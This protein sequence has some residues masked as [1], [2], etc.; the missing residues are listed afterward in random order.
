MLFE[1]EFLFNL[2]MIIGIIACL[3][4]IYLKIRKFDINDREWNTLI[5]ISAISGMVFYLSASFFDDLFHYLNGEAWGEGGITFLGGAFGGIITFTILFMIFMKRLR[6]DL[7]KYLNIIITGVVL[8]HG[9]G[10]I[11]CFFAGCCF[12]QITTSFLGVVFPV[13]SDAYHYLVEYYQA[14]GIANAEALAAVTKVL[15]TQLIE[16][17][18]LFILFGALASIKR[19]QLKVYLFAYGIFR[20]IIEFFRADNRGSLNITLS[21]SQVLSLVCI[22]LG[23]FLIIYDIGRANKQKV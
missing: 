15:P 1:Y 5:I 20:F 10:R 6:P 9:F 4:Y 3:A 12:G 23:I 21:P 18:F 22:A 13:G 2:M 17:T 19:N 7:M 8:A 16:A 11:G 14:E